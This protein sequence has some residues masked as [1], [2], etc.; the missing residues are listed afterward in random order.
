M[1]A[2]TRYPLRPH[3]TFG[4]EVVAEHYVRFDAETEIYDFLGRHL[5]H[6]APRL[7]LGGG[8]NLLF[9]GDVNGWVLHPVFGGIWVVREDHDAVYVRAMAGEKWDDLVAFAVSRGWG[10]IE[11]LSLIPGTVGAAV[12]QNIGAYGVE[13]QSVVQKV[14]GIFLDTG[15]KAHIPL[16]H[17]DFGYRS[18]R[19][20]TVWKNRFMVTAVV[21]R[22]YRKPCFTLD[23]PGICEA[24]NQLGGVS[25]ENVRSAVIAVR[26]LKLPDLEKIGSAGSFFKNPVVTEAVMNR[27][28]ADFPD[29]PTYPQKDG[30]F[31]LA[32]GWLIDR[33]GWKGKTIGHAGVHNT[34]AL[35]L[36]N[37]GNATGAEILALSQQIHDSVEQR[38]GVD[39]EREVE[40]IGN[41]PG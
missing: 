12:V 24:V 19:F 6:N 30:Q 28:R 17:C 14:E 33:C 41:K 9:V 29:L 11:N 15:E 2:H 35:V 32:A 31:K 16:E 26:K 37:D 20:K 22:L 4:V 23:Y 38:F 36:I 3:N 18:S 40:V 7:I 10:G 27:I 34:Q 39:L 1:K 13:V 25:L 5:L 21:F 8:S